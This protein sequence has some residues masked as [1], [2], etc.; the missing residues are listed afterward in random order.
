MDFGGDS[1]DTKWEAGDG[2]HPMVKRQDEGESCQVDGPSCE[3]AEDC[4]GSVCTGPMTSVACE[5]NKC[6][7]SSPEEPSDDGEGDG[8]DCQGK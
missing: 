8:E 2:Q 1:D 5:N 3:S 4:N 6:T 7:C